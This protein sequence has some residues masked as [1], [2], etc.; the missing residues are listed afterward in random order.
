MG[1][2]YYMML[3]LRFSGVGSDGLN[4]QRSSFNVLK[5]IDKKIKKISYLS[6]AAVAFVVNS[7]LMRYIVDRAIDLGK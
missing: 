3:V 2:A 7:Q 4:D 6:L 5:K 1:V